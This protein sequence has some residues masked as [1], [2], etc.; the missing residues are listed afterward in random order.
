MTTA[1]LYIKIPRATS[2]NKVGEFEWSDEHQAHIWRGKELTIEEFNESAPQ[3]LKK[4][5][6]KPVFPKVIQHQESPAEQLKQ[7]RGDH[8]RRI[9]QLSPA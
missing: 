6:G 4:Y 9:R 7:K 3:V 5:L 1:I 8:M 2:L